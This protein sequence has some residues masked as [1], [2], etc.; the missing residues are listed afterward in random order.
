ML[1]SRQL[2]TC[3]LAIF[4]WMIAPVLSCARQQQT[5]AR[6]ASTSLEQLRADYAMR[7]LEPA[8]HMAL[9][10]YFR[11][12]GDRLQ[13]FY[14][15]ETARRG[16][17]EEDEFNRAFAL[18]FH[19]S[20]PVDASPEAEAALL[21]EYARDL[22][23]PDTITK[24]ADVYISREDWAQ[25]KEYI[26]KAIRL[27]PDDFDNTDAMAEVLRREGNQAEAER[28]LG[29]YA[30]KYPQ[31]VD[32][33]RLR[34]SELSEKEP[35]RAKALLVEATRK[36]PNAGGF[37]FEMGATLQREG[38]LR[39]AEEQF[40]KAAALSPGSDYIQAW[41]GRFF[42]KVKKDD[43][44]ALD[45]YLNAY[46]LNPDAYETE[47]V[48]SRIQLISGAAAEAKLERQIKSGR[49]LTALLNDPNPMV[50]TLALE[51]MGEEWKPAYLEPVLALL[52]HDDGGVRWMATEAIKNNAGR[53]FDETLKALL[54]D[55]DLRKRGL[56][57][58]IAAHLWQ[59]ESFPVMRD[60]LREES[61][62]LRFDAVSALILEAGLEG[63]KLVSEHLTRET[64]PRL[65]KLIESTLKEASGST[66]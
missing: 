63:R 54:R 29:E 50:I 15:L 8:P 19:G 1:Q 20:Q 52:G 37:V 32:G 21:K 25:A 62:L 23:S 11:D 33:Y 16:R 7:F 47:Y 42:Y 17:F 60:M 3:C 13:A 59:Q 4:L 53:S 26:S 5:R 56:A 36:F 34:I 14:I 35:N 46:L 58:Y 65:R 39:E 57:A 40:V 22:N 44:R 27:H 41:V 30:R 38:K 48:E 31:T 18:A 12:K 64:N 9:A 24:L 49:S 10:K 6:D 28:L 51:K 55:A 45:Y 43:Q 2:R 61:Q 66:D